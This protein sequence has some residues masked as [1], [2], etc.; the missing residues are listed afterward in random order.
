MALNS[1]KSGT[2]EDL[3]S[4]LILICKGDELMGTLICVCAIAGYSAI[5]ALAVKAF[6][7]LW[8]E[9]KPAHH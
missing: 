2:I 4:N 7:N 6:R 9:F 3:E 1:M 5:V 8:E